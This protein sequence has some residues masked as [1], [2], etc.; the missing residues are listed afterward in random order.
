MCRGPGRQLRL[1]L[2]HTDEGE[3]FTSVVIE[4]RGSVGASSTRPLIATIIRGENCWLV[5][6]PEDGPL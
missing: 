6:H 4:R 5:H 2:D 3:D 1:Y